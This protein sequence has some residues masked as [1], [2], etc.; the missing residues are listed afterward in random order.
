MKLSSLVL[1]GVFLLAASNSDSCGNESSTARENP[2]V[3]DSRGCENPNCTAA[4]SQSALKPA[5]T[6]EYSSSQPAKEYADSLRQREEE[7]A[8]RYDKARK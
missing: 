4:G 7:S 3:E 1:A 8:R 2:H 5:P 6:P